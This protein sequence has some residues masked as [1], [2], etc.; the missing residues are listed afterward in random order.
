MRKAADMHFEAGEVHEQAGNAKEAMR[1]YDA[2]ASIATDMAP[3]CHSKL[4]SI[5]VG[6]DPDN[7]FPVTFV[8]VTAA[9]ARADG[10]EDNEA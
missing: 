10:S 2:A 8:E 3:Y 6:G 9:H 1:E 4:T 7:P 5:K